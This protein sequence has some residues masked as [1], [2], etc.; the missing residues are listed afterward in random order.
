MCCCLPWVRRCPEAHPEE[1]RIYLSVDI[2]STRVSRQTHELA[3]RA[4]Q[5]PEDCAFIC[6]HQMCTW[7]FLTHVSEFIASI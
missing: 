3:H 1:D 4:K 2:L 6:L 7:P 5:R